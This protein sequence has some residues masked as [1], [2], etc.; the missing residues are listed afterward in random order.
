M[1]RVEEVI[2]FFFIAREVVGYLHS[3]LKKFLQYSLILT[4][5]VIIGN[6]QPRNSG[7]RG[8]PLCIL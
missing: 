7:K 4:T 3:N 1:V 2:R 8:L 6:L 5:K